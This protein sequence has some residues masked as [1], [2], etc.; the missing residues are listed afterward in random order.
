MFLFQT[1]KVWA[2]CDFNQKMLELSV[3]ISF[4]FYCEEAY[5]LEQNEY[6]AA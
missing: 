2:V 1:S 4:T 3:S 5:Y 6:L